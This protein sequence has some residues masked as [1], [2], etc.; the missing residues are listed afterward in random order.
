[1]LGSDGAYYSGVYSSMERYKKGRKTFFNKWFYWT[2][3]DNSSN[4]WSTL[5]LNTTNLNEKILT[6]IGSAW[7][8][9]IAEFAWKVGGNSYTYIQTLPMDIVYQK[10][11]ASPTG[12][13]IYSDKISL[14]YVSDYGYASSPTYWSYKGQ[15]SSSSIKDYRAAINANWMFIGIK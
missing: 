15:D 14:M 2:S 12:G 4:Y 13:S 8:S 3:S 6:N 10:E 9:M 11:I 1:M 5:A 7:A